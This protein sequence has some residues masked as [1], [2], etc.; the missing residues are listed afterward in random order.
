MPDDVERWLNDLGLGKYAELFAENDI[1]LSVLP[2][3]SEDDLKDLGLTLGARRKIMAAIDRLAG[4][5]RSV[6][7]TKAE[8]EI[9]GLSPAEAER[10]QLTVMFCDM[11]GSTA[12]S[13][14]SHRDGVAPRP[15]RWSD[16]VR[17]PGCERSQRGRSRT[18]T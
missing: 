7:D 10:R 14:G 16:Q 15:A 6:L 11:V 12:L 9:A 17:L 5:E 18:P 1:D 13:A 2:H 4:E 8:R 3:I